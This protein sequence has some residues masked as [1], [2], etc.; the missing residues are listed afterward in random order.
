M[1]RSVFI[2]TGGPTQANA[3]ILRSPNVKPRPAA[4]AV[5][6]LQ[7]QW[8]HRLDSVIGRHVDRI[9]PGV[10]LPNAL[11]TGAGGAFP[12][13]HATMRLGF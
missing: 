9:A 8:P 13:P 3:I 6:A 2:S 7:T 4:Q 12:T 11:T 1:P 5:H 10:R